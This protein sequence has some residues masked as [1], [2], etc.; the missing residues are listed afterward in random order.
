LKPK[1]AEN[2]IKKDVVIVPVSTNIEERKSE[3]AIQLLHQ[4]QRRT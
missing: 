4:L 2:P 1:T 3:N